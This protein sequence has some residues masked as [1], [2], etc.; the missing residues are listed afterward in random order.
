[1][2][3]EVVQGSHRYH[4][5]YLEREEKKPQR[6]II[7]AQSASQ[8]ITTKTVLRILKRIES[9]IEEISLDFEEQRELRLRLGRREIISAR[10]LDIDE[11][12][13]ACIIDWHKAFDPVNW[14]K[15]V[16]ILKVTYIDGC[17]RR[18]ISKLHMDQC[19]T[20]TGQREV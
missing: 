11:K 4:N 2:K 16:Q 10:T 8:H 15:L 9:K 18:L 12:L 19:Y 20:K 5:Y 1:M 3:L 13:C 14:T 17:E 7:I 6:A